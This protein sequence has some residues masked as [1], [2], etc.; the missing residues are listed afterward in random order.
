MA[1]H[2]RSDPKT[3]RAPRARRVGFLRGVGY[4]WRGG[5]FVY[6]EHR[7]LARFWLPPVLITTALLITAGWV[8]LDVHDAVTEWLWATPA[9]DGFWAGAQ[10]VA[11][12][13]L[14]WL[15]AIALLAAAAVVVALV[16]GVIAAPFN[17]ALSEAVEHKVLAR[18]AAPFAFG[19][20]LRDVART[21]ALELLKLGAYGA[22]MVPLFG[23]G[24]FVP[25]LSPLTHGAGLVFTALYFAIDYVDS[26]A[27]RRDL[28]AR[29]RF[30]WALGHAP[31]MLGFG[32]GV[33]ALLFVPIVNL[34]FMPAA[35]A[36]GTLL[37]LELSG[38]SPA[39][40]DGRCDP[41]PG[42]RGPHSSGT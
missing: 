39:E 36:G 40:R 23:L 1:T 14:M 22:V 11:H 8:A 24:L 42:A 16:S 38:T 32:V 10:R 13:A 6:I 5:R 34:L 25:P 7:E 30:R 35:V 17:D 31:A 2:T 21:I 41:T 18:P 33:W 26:A 27:S 3:A 29:Q 4:A 9:G 15:V 20:A 19:R 12:R 37:F 28:S